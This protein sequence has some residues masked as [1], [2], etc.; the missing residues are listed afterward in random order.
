[1]ALRGSG[2]ELTVHTGVVDDNLDI[3]ASLG[4]RYGFD[5]FRNFIQ[6]RS[7]FQ[8][9]IRSSPALYAA[10]CVFGPP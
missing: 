3:L 6:L 10:A 4:E 5:E 7:D 9:A 8:R 2:V 1:M